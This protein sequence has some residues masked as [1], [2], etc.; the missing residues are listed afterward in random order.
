MVYYN[1]GS[2]LLAKINHRELTVQT[3]LFSLLFLF[4]LFL[5]PLYCKKQVPFYPNISLKY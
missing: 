1:T 2:K 5:S 3:S 4:A